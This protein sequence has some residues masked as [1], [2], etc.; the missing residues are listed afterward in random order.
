MFIVNIESFFTS[1]IK[2]VEIMPKITPRTIAPI[3]SYK[4]SMIIYNAC[5]YPPLTSYKLIVS[6]TIHVPSLNKLSP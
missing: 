5:I 1:F 6:K 4:K 3:V 2:N